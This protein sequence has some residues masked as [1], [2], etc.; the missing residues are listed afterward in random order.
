MR[1][2]GRGCAVVSLKPLGPVSEMLCADGVP[3]FTCEGRGGWDFRVVKRLADIIADTRPGLIHSLLFHANFASRRAARSAGFPAKRVVCE[4]QTVEVERRWH[5]L[6]DRWTGGSC[7]CFVGN[8]PS[9]IEHLAHHA[10][11]PRDRLRLVRGGIDPEEVRAARAIDK[12]TLV[13]GI[14]PDAPIVLWVGRLDPVKGLTFLVRAFREVAE[15]TSAH[16]VLVGG[17]PLKATLERE[18]RRTAL[19]GRVHLLG[20]RRDVPSLLKTADVFAFPSRTE[21]LPN[22]LLEAMA[23]AC[24]IVTTDVPGCRDLI[25][26]ERTGLVVPYDDTPKLTA[27]VLQLLAHPTFSAQMGKAAA[28]EVERNWHVERTWEGYSALYDDILRG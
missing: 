14:D 15:K 20:P 3:V 23:A 10:R 9:V 26:H 8:S 25:E 21:G 4:I 16:L 1:A 11:I 27:A 2:R 7:R 17:G 13:A 24:P 28:V 6:V 19:L 5:L 18:V 12:R 22:A